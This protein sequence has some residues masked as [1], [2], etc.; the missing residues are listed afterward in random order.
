MAIVGPI[1]AA[2]VFGFVCVCVWWCIYSGEG[3]KE[4]RK[5]KGRMMCCTM[6]SERLSKNKLLTLLSTSLP[7]RVPC[8][9]HELM[10]LRSMVNSQ[11]LSQ[12][13]N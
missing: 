13:S 1:K 11:L 5:R 12:T 7:S 8:P 9:T 3:R 10:A 6:N 4:E 2:Y